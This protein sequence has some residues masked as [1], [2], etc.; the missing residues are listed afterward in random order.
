MS[1]QPGRVE[2]NG[3]PHWPQRLGTVIAMA[4]ATA[5][6]KATR[7]ATPAEQASVL[8]K[9]DDLVTA[10]HTADKAE[11]AGKDAIKA[12]RAQFAM[13]QTLKARNAYR[14]AT[15]ADVLTPRTRKAGINATGAAEKLDVKRVGLL[16][17]IEAGKALHTDEAHPEWAV[18]VGQPTDEEIRLAVKIIRDE[19]NKSRKAD[20]DKAKGNAEQGGADTGVT[21]DESAP[22]QS[23]PVFADV[24]AKANSLLATARLTLDA[25]VLPSEDEQARL[26]GIIA[27]LSAVIAGE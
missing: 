27:E 23:A 2:R 21:G 18:S 8:P 1:H 15:H 7:T 26:D 6:R 19:S 5:T 10:Y 24:I 4:T 16:P 25:G 22:E 9:L 17:Y 20:K 11:V 3:Q 13:A 14:I 12:A